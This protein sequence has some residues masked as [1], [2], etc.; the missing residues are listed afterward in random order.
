[1]PVEKPFHHRASPALKQ[2]NKPFKSKFATKSTLKDKTKSKIQRKSP[3]FQVKAISSKSDRRNAAK[4]L[5]LKRREELIKA[6]R[7]FEGRGGAPKCV[8]IIPLCT[9]VNAYDVITKIFATIDKSP[10][11]VTKGITMLKAERFKQKI[12]FILLDRNFIDIMDACKAADFAIFVMS[13][14]VEVDEFG[15]RCLKGIQAQGA[16][17]VIPIVMNL[18]VVPPKKRNDS[19]KSL[20]SFMNYF[21]PDEEKVHAVDVPQEALNILRIICTQ[22]P[23]AVSGRDTHPYMLAEELA[24]EASAEDMNVGTLQV[25]GYARGVPF[26]ANRLVHLQ[27]FGDFQLKQIISCATSCDQKVNASE[28]VIDPE[29]LD[30]PNPDQMESLIAENEPDFMANEQTW[31]TQEELEENKA[32]SQSKKP[33]NIRDAQLEVKAK[34]SL[35]RVPKGTSS[36]QAAWIFNSESEGESEDSDQEMKYDDDDDT[37]EGRSHIDEEEYEDVEL[38][39]KKSLSIAYL[40]PEEEEQ[41]L[42]EYMATREKQQR[43]DLEFPDEVDTPL[44]IPA[45]IRFQRYRG[46]QNFRKSPWDP[47]ENLPIDYGRIFQF[48]N[49][50]RTSNRVM[51]EANLGAVKTGQHITLYIANVPKKVAESYDPTRPFIIFGLL[52]YEHRVSVLNFSVTR[53]SEYIEPVKSKDPLILHC[54]F[55]RYVVHPLYSQNTRGGKGTNNVH[56]FERFFNIG[57]TCIATIYG[58]IHFGSLPVMLFKDTGDVNAPILVATGF[59]HNADP[60]RIIAKRICLTGYPFKVHKKSAVVRYMFFNP[61]D[62]AWFKPVQLKTKHGRIGHIRESLGTHG[63]MKCVFDSPIKQQDTVMMNLYKRVFPK[64]NTTT[65]WDG[66]LDGKVKK[67]KMH[68]LHWCAS[69]SPRKNISQPTNAAP[70]SFIQLKHSR[71]A[72]NL[73][74]PLTTRVQNTAERQTNTTV[75]SSSAIPISPTS[76]KPL[77]ASAATVFSGPIQFASLTPH[78]RIVFP[79]SALIKVAKQTSTFNTGTSKSLPQGQRLVY[80]PQHFYQNRILDQYVT[81]SVNAITLRQLAFFGRNLTEDRL[82]QSGNY[83]RTELPIRLAHRIRDFQ[84]LP[85]IVGTNPHIAMVYDLY[86]SAFEKLRRFPQIQTMEDNVSFCTTVKELLKEHL[87]VIPQLAMGMMECSQHIP[88]EQIDLFMNKMLRSRLSRRVLAE[89][90]IALTENWH[91]SGYREDIINDGYIGVV[92]TQCHAKDIIKKVVSITQKLYQKTYGI[93]APEVLIDG[94]VDTTFAYI[95]DHIEYILCELLKN[96][97]RS[98]IEKYSP[99]I[100]R[101]ATN[102]CVSIRE[103]SS[104]KLS[105]MSSSLPPITVTVCSGSNDIYFRVSDQGGGIPDEI[106]SNLWSFSSAHKSGDNTPSLNNKFVNFDKVPKMAGTVQEQESIPPLL[107]LGIGL[108]MSKVYAEYW[109]GG[110]KIFTMNGYGTDAY[111]KITRLGNREENLL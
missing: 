74:S 95:P 58:P 111:V 76:P 25:T 108:P 86:W 56:K 41:Q 98:V 63:Y 82:L 5:Q 30:V 19:K 57:R 67:I 52:Q 50:K 9:D 97:I 8:A 73:F 110:M 28:M 64:W 91:D 53:N 80:S 4:Q 22:R 61:D 33:E 11:L 38:D 32:R 77:K 54:G 96:S 105:Q 18:Q 17:S 70:H 31:P 85:F 20:L 109:G 83:V 42:Q 40:E 93:P 24:F 14:E 79:P 6:N 46:L 13:A 34:K 90:Q 7:F 100:S 16:P 2:T 75:S 49:Y 15:E 10:P 12:Q 47:F 102:D 103:L 39:D 99:L 68:S 3:K 92:S 26:S 87:V 37:E 29:V 69:R 51:N 62:V 59:F 88:P 94:H 21:F 60:K 81:Q 72:S 107:H 1:M 36:Y 78:V 48:E 101:Q 106:Y 27:N 71:N 55:R 45:R 44:Q 84:N 35:K 43:E 66:G 65:L 23:K 104:S 89:Q